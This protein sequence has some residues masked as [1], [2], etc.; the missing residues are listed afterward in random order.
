MGELIVVI[1]GLASV[2]LGLFQYMQNQDKANDN[3]RQS[4]FAELE[5]VKLQ[6]IKLQGKLARE[7]R[8]HLET[9]EKF[10]RCRKYAI[11]LQK[12]YIK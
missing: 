9:K 3:R 7:Q 2:I 4:M 6:N 5:K 8:L 12:K 10:N 1:V 11:G